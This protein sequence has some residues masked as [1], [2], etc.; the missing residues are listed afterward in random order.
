MRVLPAIGTTN[1]TRFVVENAQAIEFAGAGMPAVLSSPALIASLERAARESLVPFLE[2]GESSVGTEI[3]LRH[4]APTP[5][6]DLVI[7]TARII[8][9]AGATVSFQVEA[10]DTHE[11]IA[12]GFHRRQVISV[13]RFARRVETKTLK[14]Q[15]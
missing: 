13:E 11:I 6:G 3:E 4:L 5:P 1:E 9:V 14:N 15:Q 2:P 10:R 7:C 8:Q 12:R